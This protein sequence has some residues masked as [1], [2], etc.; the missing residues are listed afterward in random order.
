MMTPNPNLRPIAGDAFALRV[1]RRLDQATQDLPHEVTERLRA[2]RV[3]AVEK[4]KLVL[5]QNA[6]E[7][8]AQHSTLAVGQGSHPHHWWHR[9]GAVGLLL[10]LV[11]GLYTI[12]EIQ[13]DLGA[14]ELA[15][16]DAALLTDDLPPAAY[17]DSGFV[18]FLKV[19][20]RQD[21]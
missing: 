4:H 7:V 1:A 17:L 8:Y 5:T 20:A 3:R 13:D 11:L 12:S 19:S 21:P 14:R 16:V 15:E 2:A 18:Q 10:T 6:H 9:L